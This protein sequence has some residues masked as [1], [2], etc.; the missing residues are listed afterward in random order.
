MKETPW[1]RRANILFL[2]ITKLKELE[3]E[4]VTGLEN[5]NPGG[6]KT[7]WNVTQQQKEQS[8]WEEREQGS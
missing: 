3:Q 6:K 1:K 2:E 4:G 5:L 7:G 8:G